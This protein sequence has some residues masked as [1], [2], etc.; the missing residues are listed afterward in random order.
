MNLF[1]EGL[2]AEK[3]SLRLVADDITVAYMGMGF[4]SFRQAHHARTGSYP[5]FEGE[6]EA[7]T[8]VIEHAVLADT[9]GDH[10]DAIDGH[11]G[12]FTYDV[13]EPFGQALAALLYADG[14]LTDDAAKHALLDVM[15][16]A[17]Y[18][19]MEL[20]KVFHLASPACVADGGG[21]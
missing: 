11:P 10:F 17:G 2:A 19:E 3:G 8:S 5:S 18:A 13:S 14:E 12:L 15:K 20:H 16:A 7:V 9:I 1:T 6:L 21:I 4:A